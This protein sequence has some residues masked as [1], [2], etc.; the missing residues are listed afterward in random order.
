M[1]PHTAGQIY[2]YPAAQQQRVRSVASSHAVGH[3]HCYPS[4]LQQQASSAKNPHF[5]KQSISSSNSI[6]KAF[7]RKHFFI[8]TNYYISSPYLPTHQIQNTQVTPT[9]TS[10]ILPNLGS[11][12]YSLYKPHK[13]FWAH[14]NTYHT[15][16]ILGHKIIS[17]L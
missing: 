4:L 7:N 16:T 5:A 12:K 1:N 3:I 13:L 17:S 10:H 15:I 14:T 6:Q 11:H 2:Y 8:W 9:N